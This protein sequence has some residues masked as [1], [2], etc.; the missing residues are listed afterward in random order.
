MYISSLDVF[1]FLGIALA[2]VALAFLVV[3]LSHLIGVF[4]RFIKILDE[5]RSGIKTAVDALPGFI[6]TLN[7]TVENINELS[8]KAGMVASKVNSVAAVASSAVSGTTAGLLSF[9]RTIGEAVKYSKLIFDR[10]HG[11]SRSDKCGEKKA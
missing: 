7:G 5:N 3:T 2:G 8:L 11:D 4:R 9:G 10:K 1:R 6:M